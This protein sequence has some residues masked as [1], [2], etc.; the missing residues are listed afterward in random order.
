VSTNRVTEWFG[1]GDRRRFKC[2]GDLGYCQ[3]ELA[4][5]P[6]TPGVPLTPSEGRALFGEHGWKWVKGVGDLCPGCA[7]VEAE[8]QGGGEPVSKA[9]YPNGATDGDGDWLEDER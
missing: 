9:I 2:D 7:R 8:A 4:L 1:C 3:K 6:Q 5:R